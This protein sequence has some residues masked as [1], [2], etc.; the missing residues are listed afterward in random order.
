MKILLVWPK[1]RNQV[2][3]AEALGWGT[4][5]AVAEPLALEYLVAGVESDGHE[6]RIL[7]LRLHPDDLDRTLLDFAPDVVGVTGYSLH[8]LAGLDICRRAKALLP[9]C[10]TVAGGHHATLMPEDFFESQMDFVV[11][12]EGVEPL[13]LLLRR[14][15]G[16]GSVDGIAGL[17]ARAGDR[18][19]W[20]GDQ[21]PVDLDA[22]P[23]PDRSSTSADRAAYFI[24]EM[25]PVALIRTSVGCPYRCS[26]CSL[27]KIMSGR[28]HIRSAESVVAELRTLDEEWVF[29]VDDEAFINGKRMVALAE[30][31]ASAGLRKRFFAY[32]RIDTLLRQREVVAAWRRIGLRRLFI[33]I[34]AITDELQ[35]QFNKKL[36]LAD[37]ERGLSVARELDIDVMGQFIVPTDATPLDFKRM[38]RFVEHHRIR[39][40]SFTILTPIPGTHLLESFDHLLEL[41]PNGRPNWD[42]FDCQTPVTETQMPKK[43]FMQ[44]YRGLQRLF[45]GSYVNY[46]TPDTREGASPL[47]AV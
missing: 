9:R 19:M 5:G 28:Y 26:F 36:A 11:G 43:E 2:Q 45:S 32:C 10:W 8:V 47:R 22:L 35:L 16:D 29:L 15:Q 33:G 1:A 27:W 39:Y 3:R 30:A 14:L 37:I 18:F 41:Q 7:D 13:R 25:R 31:I 20:G 24:D 17:W 44:E 23:M 40:P 46:W 42:L 4:E 12:G 21:P 34:E 38:A 6:A